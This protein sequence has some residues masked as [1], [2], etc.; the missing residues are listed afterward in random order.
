MSKWIPDDEDM[1]SL[2][3]DCGSPRHVVVFHWHACFIDDR[4]TL[5]IQTFM[6]KLPLRQRLINA[7][8]YVV[9]GKLSNYGHFESTMATGEKA[10]ELAHWILSHTTDK[11][12]E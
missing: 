5:V 3:C 7:W 1:V 8:G 9:L 10:R 11:E 6:E 2:R 12:A 4:P